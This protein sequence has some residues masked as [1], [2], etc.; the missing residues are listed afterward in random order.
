MLTTTGRKR[1][2]IQIMLLMLCPADKH[3]VCLCLVFHQSLWGRSGSLATTANAPQLTTAY[4]AFLWFNIK[5]VRHSNTELTLNGKNTDNS[6][7]KASTQ[8]YIKSNRYNQIC[9][10]LCVVESC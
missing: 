4:C 7:S 9:K 3:A 1:R 5:Y 10:Q 2:L 6:Q 8:W